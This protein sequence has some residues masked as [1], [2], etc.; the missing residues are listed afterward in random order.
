[1]EK[2]QQQGM[3]TFDQAIMDLYHQGKITEETALA[4]ADSRHNLE[5][6]IRLEKG[7]LAGNS[8]SLTFDRD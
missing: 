8:D 5:V 2:S 3:K 6:K 7:S 1:M 4:N